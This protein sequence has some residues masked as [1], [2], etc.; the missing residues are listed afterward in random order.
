[1]VVHVCTVCVPPVSM[2]I[3]IQVPTNGIFC[4]RSLRAKFAE[5]LVSVCKVP[6][7]N[8]SL[9]VLISLSH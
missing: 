8:N 5:C 6:K 3:E 4:N 7:R 2:L 9:I 1:M